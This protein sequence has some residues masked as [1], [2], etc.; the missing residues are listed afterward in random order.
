MTT[1]TR[2]PADPWPAPTARDPVRAVVA[3]PGS[4]SG[5]NRALALAAAADG[6]SRLR[7]AL[8][9]RDTLLMA[10][11]LRAL[12]VGID[13]DGSAWVVRG[14]LGRRD[15]TPAAVDCGNAGT[16]A[17]FTPALA[18]LTDGDVTFDGDPRMR[19]RP[20]T[21]LLTAL[22]GL[23]AVVDGDTMPLVVHGR[24][25]IAGGAVTVDASDSSQLISGL[26][27]AAP[28]YDEGVEVSHVGG[29][30]PSGPYLDMTVTDLRAAGA[31]VETEPGD[32]A[33]PAGRPPTW[34]VSPGRLRA[35]DRAIE[36][37]LNSAAPFLAA[38]VATGGDVTIPDWPTVTTQPGR[39]L[40]GLLEAMGAHAELT[41]QGLRVRGGAG[42]HGL[43][44]DLGDVG[45]AAPVL[46]ALAV[47]ADSP[48]R[49]RGIA[50]LRLQETDRLGALADQ[51][52]RLGADISVTEDGLAIRPA[53]LRGA[54][55]DPLA[56][57]RLA[58]TYAVVG[59][60]VPGITVDDIATTGK[61]VPEF[62]A[63]WA[64]MLAA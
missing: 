53:P 60:R 4:K 20:L 13:H 37:D 51:L 31:T 15:G 16:V 24:G 26:L 9:S 61:T 57:H 35:Y 47:L 34:R 63:M 54:R 43:D 41:P 40:P 48:S 59:L 5:T 64:A 56:D 14:G 62:P 23:G 11:A 46:T 32:P 19:Q 45:E 1:A 49:L 29:R 44:A 18:A 36:P 25:G 39:M 30:L 17:R 55:L 6:V 38:A 3:V 33:D 12:G 22:R 42:L 8:R 52:G 10:G 58:M 21:P 7:G 50:H 27:L 28:G 2:T